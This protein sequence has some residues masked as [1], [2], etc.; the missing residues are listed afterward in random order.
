MKCV[1]IWHNFVSVTLKL[2]NTKVREMA[3]SLMVLPIYACK[4]VDRY[5][6][7]LFDSVSFKLA[8]AK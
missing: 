1:M 7:V 4:S 2:S 6:G 3:Y 8:K 5:V